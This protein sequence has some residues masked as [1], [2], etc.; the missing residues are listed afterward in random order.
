MRGIYRKAANGSGKEEL[1]F[2]IQDKARLPSDWSRDGRFLIFTEVDPKTRGDIW[3]LQDPGKPE[4]KPVRF[5]GTEANESQGQLSPDGRWLAYYSEETGGSRE[6]YVRQ[7]P[8]GEGFARVSVDGGREPRWNKDG[9]ELYYLHIGDRGYE[10]MA[11]PIQP[12]GR[13]G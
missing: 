12:D 4:S 2:A 8:S 11:V 6:V 9:T 1:L 7:F 5:L 3:Y 13:G 10:L